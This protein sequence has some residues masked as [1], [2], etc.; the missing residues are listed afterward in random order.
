MQIYTIYL[1]FARVLNLYKM[2]T[3]REIIYMILDEMK[4]SA[5][6]AYFT[7]DH[8]MYLI[9]KYRVFILK[10][11]Y[12]DIKKQIPESNYQTICLDLIEVPA[13][14][15]EP[16][17][18]G[19]YLRSKDKIPFLMQVGA[20]KVYPIDYY[21]GEITYVSRERMRYVGYNKYLQNIIYC[22]IGPD[23]Y[24]YF[25]SN[26]PQYL[27][28]EKVRMTGIFEDSVSAS[29]LQCSN[30]KEC[31]I[32]DRVFP[33]EDSLVPVVIELVV[34]ELLGANYRPKDEE[35]NAKDDLAGIS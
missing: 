28:L 17:E 13:I 12:S 25:K 15:G 11:R 23:N 33:L 16:C 26:N 18:G 29:N 5:D 8:I 6:D 35:N 4:I 10:Q 14:S 31:D 1:T 30:D 32:L 22:S 34:K 2:S 9:N 24:L 21:Q 7:E 19:S 27:Y 3:F 20:P